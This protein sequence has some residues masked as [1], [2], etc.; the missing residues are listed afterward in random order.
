M[1]FASVR[2]H[3]QNIPVQFLRGRLLRPQRKPFIIIFSLYATREK[4][5]DTAGSKVES[6]VPKTHLW[7]RRAVLGAVV[8]TENRWECAAVDHRLALHTT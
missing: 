4:M 6:L 7:P 8:G 3:V 1:N 2:D 5:T